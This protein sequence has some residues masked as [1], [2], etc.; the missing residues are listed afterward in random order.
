MSRTGATGEANTALVSLTAAFNNILNNIAESACSTKFDLT[1][2]ICLIRNLTT[3][4]IGDALPVA[5][6]TSQGADLSRLKHYRNKI[7]HCGVGILSDKEFEECWTEISQVLYI[8]LIKL[9]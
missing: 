2:M 7:V 8:Y 6:D 4:A 1:L 5:S 9:M 3:I